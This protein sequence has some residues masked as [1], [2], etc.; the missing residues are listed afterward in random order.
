MRDQEIFSAIKIRLLSND[1]AMYVVGF[2]GGVDSISLVHALWQCN[3]KFIAAHFN[4]RLRK[5]SDKEVEKLQEFCGHLNIP[6]IS[7]VEDIA[8]K[9]KQEKKGIEETAR[10]FR[11][12]FL[13]DVASSNSAQAVLTAHTADDQSETIL[14]HLIRGSG[15]KGLSG[16][17]F[18][19]QTKYHPTI[20][21]IR[22]LLDITR[23]QTLAYCEEYMLDPI[24]DVSNFDT[25][26]TRNWVRHDVIPLLKTHNPRINTALTHLAK[27]AREEEAAMLQVSDYLTK[28]I[29]RNVDGEIHLD[30]LAFSDKLPGMQRHILIH[31]LHALE[32]K[33]N[34]VDFQGI[35]TLREYICN[36]PD[37]KHLKFNTQIEVWFEGTKAIFSRNNQKDYQIDKKY[38]GGDSYLNGIGH[39]LIN[40]EWMIVA[41]EKDISEYEQIKKINKEDFSQ[42]FDAEKLN[43]PL[44]IRV[45]RQGEQFGPLG[46]AGKTQKISDY[47]INLKVPKRKRAFVPL[48][49]SKGE[50]IWIIGYQIA[51]SVKV[52][53][54][55]KKIVQITLK[56]RI[57]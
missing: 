11:Y 16:M 50:V 4:H 15:L 41:I 5:T 9:A 44:T 12:Q 46:M 18:L 37:T 10:D 38:I 56:K 52:T 31:V 17:D 13:F 2:S 27:I 26:Y 30:L 35:E 1:R 22:P 24:I 45:A 7:A 47:F 39:G 33:D 51:D 43:W 57:T 40:N 54:K 49:I 25:K 34:D 3:V 55:T 23:Q 53:E 20:P 32:Y 28:Q 19:S 8:K 42:F 48:V 6:F 29:S 36:P 21:L 14:M